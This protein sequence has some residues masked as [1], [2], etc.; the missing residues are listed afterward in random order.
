MAVKGAG[1]G[2]VYCAISWGGTG[3]GG[4][5]LLKGVFA[6]H[7]IYVHPKIHATK[8]SLLK[9]HC[10]SDVR[11]FPRRSLSIETR[12]CHFSHARTVG[13]ASRYLFLFQGELVNYVES[14]LL[15]G[16]CGSSGGV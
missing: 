14:L 1:G 13:T 6:N 4:C 2:S 11:R 9:A 15:L 16:E 5:A 7:D 8:E 12:A 10:D 3:A